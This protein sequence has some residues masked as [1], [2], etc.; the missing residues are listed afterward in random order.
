MN[1]VGLPQSRIET[2]NPPTGR[3]T[4]VLLEHQQQSWL[5]T[6]YFHAT[7]SQNRIRLRAIASFSGS[8]C[9][10]AVAKPWLFTN[11]KTEW[12]TKQCKFQ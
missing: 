6:C 5:R 4:F 8:K 7:I 2:S 1:S 9:L 12:S 3:A 10:A 11:V